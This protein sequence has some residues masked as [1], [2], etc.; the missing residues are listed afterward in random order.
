M[1][2]YRRMISALLIVISLIILLFGTCLRIDS[3][4][5][6]IID[7]SASLINWMWF[8]SGEG[9]TD[10]I[11]NIRYALYDNRLTGIE[12]AT[13]SHDLTVLKKTLSD[14]AVEWIRSDCGV[15][16]DRISA[17]LGAY[18]FFFW[19]TVAIG[20]LSLILL[21]IWQ[22]KKLLSWVYPILTAGLIVVYLCIGNGMRITLFPFM[23][24]FFALLSRLFPMLSESANGRPTF[25]AVN[26]ARL[27]KITANV[28][29]KGKKLHIRLKERIEKNRIKTVDQNIESAVPY[30][31]RCGCRAEKDASYCEHC[32]AKL[33]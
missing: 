10:S 14:D 8:Y 11:T 30:C 16:L 3:Q 12:S 9:S 13:V 6:P 27:E 33:R 22:Q 15:D 21:F 18:V 2:K 26:G 25:A 31:P 24:L 19:F 5:S 29:E 20:L 4:Y 28:I 1:Y 23:V 32:G 7:L 17:A